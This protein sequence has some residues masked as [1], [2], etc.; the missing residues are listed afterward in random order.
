MADKEFLRITNEWYRSDPQPNGGAHKKP[1]EYNYT[2]SSSVPTNTIRIQIITHLGNTVVSKYSIPTAFKNVLSQPIL[3]SQCDA[4]DR[5]DKNTRTPKQATH[6][7]ILNYGRTFRPVCD[8]CQNLNAFNH[9]ICLETC[10]P[11]KYI[12]D[13]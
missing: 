6:L 13:L 10:I 11:F 4:S 9:Y 1:F 8:D 5:A 3:C 7:C 2:M 12:I